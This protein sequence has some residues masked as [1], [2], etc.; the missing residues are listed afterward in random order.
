MSIA[1]GRMW[2][3]TNKCVHICI[4]ECSVIVAVRLC[5]CLLCMVVIFLFLFGSPDIDGQFAFSGVLSQCLLL[6]LILQVLFGF[7]T[8]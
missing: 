3:D 1:H 5:V 6:L 4:Y 7:V 8:K 2:S